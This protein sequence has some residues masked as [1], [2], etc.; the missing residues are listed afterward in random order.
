VARQ[1]SGGG[2]GVLTPVYTYDTCLRAP[3]GCSPVAVFVDDPGQVA[4]ETILS[5]RSLS[6]DGRF[7]A[8]LSCQFD[9]SRHTAQLTDSCIGATPGCTTTTSVLADKNSGGPVIETANDAVTLTA[10][11]RFASFGQ[12]IRGNPPY[13]TVGDACIAA[14]AGC[15]LKDVNVSESADGSAADKSSYHSMLSADGSRVVFSSD[16]TNLVPG[17]V[18]G[19]RDIFVARTGLLR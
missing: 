8:Y 3:A 1:Q 4:A 5:D 10:D 17:D 7:V 2:N 12:F 16:A 19:L 11:G 18:N 13:I 9:C 15:T 6:A 14:P